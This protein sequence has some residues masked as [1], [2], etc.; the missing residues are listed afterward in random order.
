[1]LVRRAS[2]AALSFAASVTPSDV[3]DG[4]QLLPA[5]N[6]DGRRHVPDGV[7]TTFIPARWRPYLERARAAGEENL[8]KHY[9][10]LCVLFAL[11]GALRSGEI[12]V[13]GSRRY[14]NP[15]SYLIPAE[16]WPSRRDE[17]L[18][19]TVMPGTFAERLATI[20]ADIAR[21][22]DDLEVL[23]A[24]P[25]GPVRLD[26]HGELHLSPLAAE[27]VDPAV[28]AERDAVV[29]RLPGLPLTELLIESDLEAT[30]SK[31]LTHAGG[32]KPRV[33]ALEHRRN[34]YAAI[35]A[36]ACNYGTSRMAELTGISVDTLDWTT[37]WYLREETL[38]PANADMINAHH[39]HALAGALG[40]GTLSSSDGL[41]LSMRGKSLTAPTRRWALRERRGDRPLS[42]GHYEPINPYGVLNIDIAD[43]VQRPRRPVRGS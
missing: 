14:A 4:V 27:V 23:L 29:A 12:W 41:R 13:E 9:W 10:E 38:R 35:I 26:E 3:L 16:D 39:R 25:D 18:E 31:H 22:P 24:D 43:V 6:T 30:W 19:L 32:A 1:M 7:P 2:L 28:L 8:H 17:A 15:A 21:Y 5:M 36:Q 42:P 34:L 40:G 33:P 20:D 37:Q 11:Q